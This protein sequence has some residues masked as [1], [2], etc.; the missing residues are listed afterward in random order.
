[1]KQAHLAEAVFITRRK[2]AGSPAGRRLRNRLFTCIFIKQ[3]IERLRT[4]NEKL[5]GR[6]KD[7]ETHLASYI[8]DN[9]TL[10]K[11]ITGLGATP[12]ASTGVR[13]K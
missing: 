4:E 11:Q 5:A 13:I 12:A 1:M 7:L 2:L 9:E 8:K 3:E 6:S 10:K